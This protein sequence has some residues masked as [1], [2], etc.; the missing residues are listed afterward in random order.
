ML[1]R[2]FQQSNNKEYLMTRTWRILIKQLT[3][4]KLIS[5]H[6]DSNTTTAAIAA[7]ADNNNNN[8]NNNNCCYNLRKI[9][10][11]IY[12]ILFVLKKL[13]KITYI[14]EKNWTA[15]YCVQL[16]RHWLEAKFDLIFFLLNWR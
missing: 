7:A 2:F 1:R 9:V 10:V 8:N 4:Q 12:Y 11:S 3:I 5:L 13:D 16:L 14:R 6:L 15:E